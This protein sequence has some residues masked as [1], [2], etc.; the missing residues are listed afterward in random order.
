MPMV[1]TTKVP[2]RP[3]RSRCPLLC[4][5]SDSVS[6]DG[7]VVLAPH[8]EYYAP[9]SNHGETKALIEPSSGIVLEDFEHNRL[10]R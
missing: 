6:G 3:L 1:V 10:P 7:W 5:K 8:S 4:P 9:L 2:A